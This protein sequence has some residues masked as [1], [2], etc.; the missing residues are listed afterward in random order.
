MVAMD[1]ARAEFGRGGVVEFIEDDDPDTPA[2]EL[3]AQIE[4]EPLERELIENEDA[5]LDSLANI[6]MY[7]VAIARAT[8]NEKDYRA[9]CAAE[10]IKPF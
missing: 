1:A 7:R 10:G 2:F 6:W 4:L 9:A 5:I 3:P 8:R